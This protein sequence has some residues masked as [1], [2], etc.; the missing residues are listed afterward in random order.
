[1]KQD[2]KQQGDLESGLKGGTK[3]PWMKP[4]LSILFGKAT[5]SG[6]DLGAS[7]IGVSCHLSTGGATTDMTPASMFT[8]GGAC[9]TSYDMGTFDVG[10]PAIG[11]S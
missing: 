8:P 4:K 5:R 9:S 2:K 7:E 1:M 6:K 11:P 3:E 10:N